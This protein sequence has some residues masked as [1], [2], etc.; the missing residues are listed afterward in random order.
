[1][2]VGSFIHKLHHLGHAG[3]DAFPLF[4]RRILETKRRIAEHLPLSVLLGSCRRVVNV[5]HVVADVKRRELVSFV[6]ISK[7]GR[8]RDEKRP[9]GNPEPEFLFLMRVEGEIVRLRRVAME[10]PRQRLTGVHDSEISGVVDELF[11]LIRG[12]CRRGYEAIRDLLELR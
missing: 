7:V 1:M 10:E 2:I 3:V 11:I 6:R 12:R 9:C 8:L 5:N 4:L